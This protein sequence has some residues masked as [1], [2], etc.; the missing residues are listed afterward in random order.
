MEVFMKKNNISEFVLNIVKTLIISAVVLLIVCPL[1]CRVTEEGIVVIDENYSCPKIENF[2]V[3]SENQARIVFSEKVKINEYSINPKVSVENINISSSENG[4]GLCI[5]D[6]IFSDFL[7]IG[8]EYQFYGEVSD[9]IGNTLTFSLPLLGF[10]GKVPELEIT[11]V[12][13]KYSSGTNSSGKYY[14][15]EYVELRVLS[16]GN[17]SGLELYSA[18]DSSS[19]S[20]FFPTI[21]VSKGEIIIVHLRTKEDSSLAVSEINSDFTLSKAK[22]SSDNARDLWAENQNARIGD[23]MDVILLRNSADN[24]IIDCVCYAD[25]SYSE[26]KSEEMQNAIKKAVEVG[27]WNSSSIADSVR[28]TKLTATKS[29]ERISSEYFAKGWQLSKSSGETPGVVAY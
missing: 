2:Y 6:F 15:C 12:H 18:N 11:E 28:F 21:E 27:K 20:Y 17:L 14:K 13:P 22:Y 16:D 23:D 7:E 26:W 19:K 8:E 9:K 3:T 25:E 29:L 10:N 24:S 1:S 4:E 5:Y